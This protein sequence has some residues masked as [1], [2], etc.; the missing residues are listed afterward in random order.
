MHVRYL[1]LTKKK[2]QIKRTQ[3][4]KQANQNLKKEGKPN[5]KVKANKVIG[6]EESIT[7]STKAKQNQIKVELPR[8]GHAKR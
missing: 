2:H 8:C 4:Q 7:A 1:P 5:H 6:K 3:I